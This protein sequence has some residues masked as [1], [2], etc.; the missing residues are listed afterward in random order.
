MSEYAS[1][2]AAGIVAAQ[3]ALTAVGKDKTNTYH[4]YTYAS[5]EAMVRACREAL[6]AGGLA[7]THRWDISPNEGQL[8]IL[9]DFML[10]HEEGEHRV[11]RV[12]WPV[13]PEKGRP[14]D[15]AMA[16]ALT[17]CMSYY[18]RGL[19]LVPRDDD[20]MDDR[21]DRAYTPPAAAKPRKKAKAAPKQSETK[22]SEAQPA[23][24]QADAPKSGSVDIVPLDVVE[25]HVHEAADGRPYAV[26]SGLVNGDA[27]DLY[28]FDDMD[29]ARGLPNTVV[30]AEIETRIR[31]NRA[32]QVLTSW[33]ASN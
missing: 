26:V 33:R 23:D 1:K 20:T 18:L 16:A 10:V 7:V 31:N 21:D 5:A 2:I 8:F 4:R 32:S 28:H 6:H 19:L 3:R 22:Q 14:I 25:V 12:T 30:E 9:V 17:S 11:D 13:V 15:K 24:A 27:V 29:A